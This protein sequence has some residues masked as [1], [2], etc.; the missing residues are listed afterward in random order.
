MKKNIFDM[1]F[2]FDMDLL[3]IVITVYMS[4]KGRS[5]KYKFLKNATLVGH[6]MVFI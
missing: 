3:L 6:A 5:C 2:A 4:D 1:F